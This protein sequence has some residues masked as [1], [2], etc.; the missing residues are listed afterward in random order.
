MTTN[1]LESWHPVD[2]IHGKAESV[3]VVLDGQFERSTDAALFF[4]AVYMNVVVIR[5]AIGQVMYQLWI[6]VKV[7]NDRLVDREERV[8]VRI[9]ESVGML[10]IW[11]QLEEVD[12][13]DEP[14]LEVGKFPA[15]QID[16]GPG[17]PVWECLLRKPSL[18][19][20]PRIHR[21]WPSP[22]Y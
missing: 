1:L 15:K 21:C 14:H 13:I 10:G 6:A 19:L 7:E 5:S 20:V 12:H 2:D 3:N 18:R 4:L 11:L 8:E 22:R 17:I 9:R 16:R